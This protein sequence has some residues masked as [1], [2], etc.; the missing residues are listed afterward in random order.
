M[1]DSLASFARKLD[2]FSR[3][4]SDDA[5]GHA[6][7]KMA[8]ESAKKAAQGDLGSDGVFSGWKAKPLDTRY[9]IIGPGRVSFHPTKRG[10]GPWTVADVGRNQA[11]GPRLVGPRLTQTGRVSKARQKRWNGRTQGKGTATDA[12]TAIE[13]ELPKVA[14]QQIGR[15]IRKVF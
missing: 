15:A 11:A 7:G 10:A 12:L 2:R 13:R 8:K 14:D 4:L 5:M 3:E 1:A 9:E 6:I